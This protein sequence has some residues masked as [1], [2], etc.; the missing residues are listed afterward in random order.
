[1]YH[2]TVNFS[3]IY[4]RIYEN[5]E[6]KMIEYISTRNSKEKVTA[7]QAIL[8][9]QAPDGGL[10]VPENLDALRLGDYRDVTSKDFKGMAKIIWS[11]FFPDY[12]E[13]VISDLVEKSYNGKFSSEKITP[14]SVVDDDNFV[15]ELYHGPTSAFKDVALSALPN[16]MTKAREIVG[17]K[18]EILILTATSGDTGSAA[19]HGFKDVSG[20]RI[21]VFYPNNGVSA[22]QELQMLGVGGNNTKACAINGNFDD[23][24][25]GVKKLFREI[26]KPRDGV[27]LS[28]ANSINI[29]RLVPQVVY[30]FSAY[31]QMVEA[32]AIK[33]GE[34]LNFTVPTG[35]FGDILAGYFAMKMGLPVNKLICASNKNDV[36]TEF[37][38]T[39]HYDR[40]RDF[41]KTNSPSMDILIS[42]NLERLLY[43]VCGEEN[44]V[45]YMKELA[46]TGEY[47]I[48]ASELAEIQYVFVGIAADDDE[49]SEAITS[50]F[51]KYHYLM[52]THTSIAWSCCDKYKASGDKMANVVLSTASP[53][54]FCP[55]V[56]KALGETCES[57][58]K[59][60]MLKL[61]E[62][63]GTE[64]PDNLSNL[65]DTKVQ[66]RTVIEISEMRDFL[67][68]EL[69]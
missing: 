3:T 12:G 62:K 47:Q 53:Y 29:G 24:Q 36:L 48:S 33:D 52:D 23:A 1:M 46:E 68:S 44:T 60:N 32:G 58:D 7:P 9:G 31:K 8:N 13:D 66:E 39:G 42:S 43:Y 10:Y 54:K 6:K 38:Q 16:L 21:L 49:G 55:A 20:T 69:C 57:S 22:T 4:E 59:E 67:I 18:D 14:L 17:F 45:K 40:K 5:G 25:S 61:Q 65:F 15:L 41:Y 63:T 64:I 34:K 19:L 30:Y 51:N 27:S 28:S 35:N 2:K 37:L 11:K 50:V 56:L 26:P